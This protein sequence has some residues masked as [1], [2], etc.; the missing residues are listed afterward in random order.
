MSVAAL[1]NF[2]LANGPIFLEV[3]QAVRRTVLEMQ[4]DS[5][6]LM[7]AALVRFV[8]DPRVINCLLR[9]HIS[10]ELLFPLTGISFICRVMQSK[11]ISSF[12]L[13]CL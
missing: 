8:P 12:S 3:V 7:D 5:T 2:T 1:F 10:R 11:F 4:L 9:T 6:G 13:I